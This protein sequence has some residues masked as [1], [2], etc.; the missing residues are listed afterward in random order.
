MTKLLSIVVPTKNRYYYLKYLVD[1]FHS[2]DTDEIE[3]IIQD[4][5]DVQDVIFNAYLVNLGDCRIIY[6]YINGH[7]SVVENSDR[8]LLNASGEYITFIGDDDIF[9]KHI[10]GFVKEA[11]DKN[12]DAI[13]P[14][15]SS[16]TWPDV[17]PRLYGEKLSGKFIE[18][19]ITGTIKYLDVNSILDKVLRLGGTNILNLPR[20]YHGIVKH[21]ILLKVRQKT[22]SFFPGPSPDM[23]NAV[24]LCRYVKSFIEVDV[25]FIISGHSGTSAGG[26]GAKGKHFGEI[27][28]LRHLP[29]NTAS[30]WSLYVP[31]YWSGYTIYAESVIK[32]LERM[33]LEALLEK[34]NYNYLYATCLVFDTNYKDRVKKNIR[35]MQKVNQ[36]SFIIILFYYF[37]VW[38]NR[39]MHHL[40]NNLK[41]IFIKEY[42][43]KKEIHKGIYQLEDIFQVAIINDELI[44]KKL[45]KYCF[46]KK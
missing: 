8:A 15:K 21:E 25:P 28:E 1:Y 22:G 31:Y 37:D 26:Q 34:F 41:L 30:D 45:N 39:L 7:I 9:S 29:K 38:K 14:L 43:G 18:T 17:K 3:L 11:N 5:S 16:Y 4:N 36:V 27:A 42:I 12:I 13:L 32:A 19:Q 40:I 10:I 2:I 35:A 44:E 23:A 46:V 24:A 20:L 33:N 6:N